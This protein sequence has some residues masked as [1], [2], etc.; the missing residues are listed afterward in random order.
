[1]KEILDRVLA[2]PQNDQEKVVRFV[3]ELE[4][5][6]AEDVIAGEEWKVGGYPG[7]R[8]FGMNAARTFPRA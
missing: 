3:Q 7:A 1:M 5:W 6:G 4:E 8:S 2:W